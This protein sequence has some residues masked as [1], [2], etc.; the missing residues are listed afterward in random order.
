M[1]IFVLLLLCLAGCTG[2][3]YEEEVFL[4]VDGSG[5]LR[6]SG[7][8]EALGILLPLRD[9][10][11]DDVREYFDGP[12]MSLDSVRE[13]ERDGR[14]FIHVRARFSSWNRLCEHPAFSARHCKLVV[15]PELLELES[16]LP[17]PA[18]HDV[19][20]K[21]DATMAF[22]FHFPSTVRFHNSP[23]GIER[24]NIVRWQRSMEELFES[25]PLVIR[26][27]FEKHSVLET[28]MLVL[29]VATCLVVIS[30]A[31]AILLM[32][33]KGRRQLEED[34]AHQET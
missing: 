4:N 1:R 19:P 22:R 32:V 12:Q 27:R 29:V 17:R 5:Q 30:V 31:T 2:Y 34:A 23:N 33:R 20:T 26:A 6:I 11:V 25:P 3:E 21:P 28:T 9:V 10:P 14:T 18:G 24:G 7:S 8:K 13:S 15:G 16:T